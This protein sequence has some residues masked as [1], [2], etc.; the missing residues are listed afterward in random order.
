MTKFSGVELVLYLEAFAFL[1]LP[2]PWGIISSGLLASCPE[3]ATW[4]AKFCHNIH[5]RGIDV[6]QSQA[7][8][9]TDLTVARDVFQVPEGE[10]PNQAAVNRIYDDNYEFCCAQIQIARERRQ[11]LI[12]TLAERQIRFLKKAYATLMGHP[13]FTDVD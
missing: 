11:A 6:F 10:E 7:R 5:P 3:V 13:R 12:I 4:I 1:L 2:G 8:D 9:P